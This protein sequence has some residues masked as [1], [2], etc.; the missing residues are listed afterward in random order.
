MD[1]L[2]LDSFLFEK[3]CC[4][5]TA[6]EKTERF[7]LTV[8]FQRDSSRGIFE[9]HS[10]L[11]AIDRQAEVNTVHQGGVGESFVFQPKELSIAVKCVIID[12][13]STGNLIHPHPGDT[14][15]DSN[16]VRQLP[17]RIDFDFNTRRESVVGFRV[18]ETSSTVHKPDRGPR[19]NTVIQ[20]IRGRKLAIGRKNIR[21]EVVIVTS[22][23]PL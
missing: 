12:F 14:E 6:H 18:I 1:I 10:C 15:I 9:Y 22:N 7:F 17:V 20:V 13:R 5:D 21:I 2:I 23:A 11:V 8:P 16:S 3:R 4:R 19:I